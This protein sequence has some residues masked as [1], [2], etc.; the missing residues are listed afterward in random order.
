M[1]ATHN[2]LITLENLKFDGLQVSKSQKIKDTFE[3]MISM[4]LEFENS[5][6]EV[7]QLSQKEITIDVTKKAKKLRL[8]IAKIRIDTEKIRK[9]QKEEILKEGKAIDG[10]A[11]ILKYAVSDHEKNLKK[12]EDYFAIQEKNRLDEIQNQRAIRLSE[13]V[14]DAYER[15]LLKF[16]D[17]E[18][19]AFLIFKKN[20]KIEIQ[21]AEAEA[22]H[23]K[24][25]EQ[26]KQSNYKKRLT[27]ISVKHL[28][29]HFDFSLLTVNTSELEYNTLINEAKK[30]LNQY[31]EEAERVRLE[32]EKLRE[33]ARQ[34]ELKR[35]KAEAEINKRKKEEADRLRNEKKI[36]E[37]ELNKN[38]AQKIDDLLSELDAVSMKYNFQSEKNKKLYNQ[39]QGFILEAI[40]L[41]QKNI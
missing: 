11:N 8:Q 31:N 35:K 12:I 17:D 14:D 22:E 40:I 34:S 28:S 10:V 13:F 37:L 36:L 18:F 27:D 15:D 29:Q 20:E 32:N 33:Q 2:G 21:K 25:L 16:E 23:I 30:R 19:E 38:D 41:I 4:L 39:V 3:P 6:N 24:H 9:I 26:E 7:I 5:Y 1:Q